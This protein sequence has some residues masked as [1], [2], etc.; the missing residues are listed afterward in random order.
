[1]FDVDPV[2]TTPDPASLPAGST[3]LNHRFEAAHAIMNLLKVEAFD[4][5]RQKSDRDPYRRRLGF[6]PRLIDNV[7]EMLTFY[8]FNG[9]QGACMDP[10][11]AYRWRQQLDDARL[12]G[13]E[14]DPSSPDAHYLARIV[15]LRWLLVYNLSVHPLPPE[16][17]SNQA[18]IDSIWDTVWK[19]SEEAWSGLAYLRLWM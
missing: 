1:M 19:V 15:Y 14:P 9:W 7:K 8:E 6:V 4:Y 11:L 12:Q 17:P 13:L 5:N 16:D 2:Y 18:V 10:D 3:G